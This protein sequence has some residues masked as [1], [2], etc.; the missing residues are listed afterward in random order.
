MVRTLISLDDD[1]KSWLDEKSRSEHVPMT[2]LVRKA[3]RHYRRSE[4]ASSPKGIGALLDA[5]KGVWR[6]GDGLTYQ[7]RAR[8]EWSRR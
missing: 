2:A 3:I 1:D 8:S 4:A 5:T 7:R 6:K